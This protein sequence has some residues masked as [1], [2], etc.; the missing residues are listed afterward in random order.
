MRYAKVVFNLAVSGPFDYIIP[1]AL[2]NKLHIGMR[3]KVPFGRRII[4]GFVIGITSKSSIKNLKKIISLIDGSAVLDKNLISLAGEMAAYYCCT[5]GEALDAIFPLSSKKIKDSFVSDIKNSEDQSGK[6]TVIHELRNEKRW[7]FY[8]EQLRF[9][10]GEGKQGIVVL[11]DA[12]S[13]KGAKSLVERE[14]KATVAVL[15]RKQKDFTEEWLRVRKQQVQVIIGTRSAV[16]APVNNPGVLII[17]QEEDTVYKQDQSPHY[18]AREIA[19][20][21][22]KIDNSNLVLGSAAPSLESYYLV[23]QKKAEYVSGLKDF[24]WPQ[25]KV[26]NL[27]GAS[28]YVRQRGIVNLKFLA[29]SISDALLN[30]QKALLFINRRGFATSSYCIHC[31][32]AIKCPRC[33][34]NLVYHYRSGNLVCH[35]CNYK[36]EPP[37][38]CPECNS[39]YIKYSGGGTEKIESE[40]SRIFPQ[41]KIKR[42][43]D[44]GYNEETDSA[45]IYVATQGVI[46]MPELKF[47]LGV[48]LSI[49]ST[50]HRTDF[51][52]G[53][54]AYSIFFNLAAFISQKIFIETSL[55]SHHSIT[56]LISHDPLV[57]Y[58]NE[59]KQRRALGFPPFKHFCLVKLRGTDEEKVEGVGSKLFEILKNSNKKKS[60]SIISIN[61]SQPPQKRGQYY[62]QILIS[63]V[64]PEKISKF[65]KINLKDFRHSGIIVT[66]DMDPI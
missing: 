16:F 2:E 44:G 61:P 33:N 3:V 36:I 54:R 52:A 40:L 41:A 26:I 19:I 39:G 64:W 23:K 31:G 58:E 56:S 62:W 7:V 53:E 29:D 60:I 59:L 14:L 30:K 57:F 35:Y 46:K 42:L 21:R 27:K 47:D 5:D 18:H 66:V 51:R 1:Q 6:I 20:M 11:P 34:C 37:K 38:I 28:S 25:V 45:D 22:Q 48:I 50:L 10:L 13:I 43:D 4:S 12:H 32:K 8:I 24:I 17:E 9:A 55:S 65:L 49:D 15:Y 63:S